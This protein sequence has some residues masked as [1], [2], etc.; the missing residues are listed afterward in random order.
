ML[1]TWIR[2]LVWGKSLEEHLDSL[3]KMQDS[4]QTFGERTSVKMQRKRDRIARLNAEASR[5]AAD[6]TRA[7]LVR[8]NLEVLMTKPVATQ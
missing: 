8:D 4:L 1:F 6:I 3:R 7:G 2:W 5:N